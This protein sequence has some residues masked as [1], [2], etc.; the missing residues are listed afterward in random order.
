[1]IYGELADR[2]IYHLE[3]EL[4]DARAALTA[5]RREARVQEGRV[6]AVRD[7]LDRAHD[8][9]ENASDADIRHALDQKV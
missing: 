1:M 3:Q 6:E 9:F 8:E 5:A 4:A 2:R 7:V